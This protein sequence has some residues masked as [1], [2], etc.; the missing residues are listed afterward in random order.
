MQCMVRRKSADAPRLMATRIDLVS[1]AH[2]RCVRITAR[3]SSALR[4][5]GTIVVKTRNGVTVMV[6]VGV[7]A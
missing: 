2:A 4:Y 7:V 5:S 3:G 1:S 6:E